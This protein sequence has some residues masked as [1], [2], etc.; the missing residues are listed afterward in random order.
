MRALLR[1]FL[2]LRFIPAIV[3]YSAL[4]IVLSS[5]LAD[6][7]VREYFES[8]GMEYPADVSGVVLMGIRYAGIDRDELLEPGARDFVG[9]GIL[10][11]K[12]Y[13]EKADV[14]SLIP[15]VNAVIVKRPVLYRD[16]SGEVGL[17]VTVEGFGSGDPEGKTRLVVK[18]AGKDRRFW[19]VENFAY[20]NRSD[21]YTWKFGGWVY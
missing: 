16:E 13:F 21:F 3:I 15:G 9:E 5:C 6:D 12:G 4:P 14:P 20:F 7:P 18:W 19:K 11:V 17:M 2:A 8:H 10:F 1:Y